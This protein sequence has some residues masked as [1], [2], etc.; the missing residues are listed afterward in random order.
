MTTA[1][2]GMVIGETVPPAIVGVVWLGTAR[3][4]AWAGWWSR[5]SP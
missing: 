3:A 2:A 1:V 5:D 4:K